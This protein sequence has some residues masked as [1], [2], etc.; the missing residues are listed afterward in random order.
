MENNKTP[1]DKPQNTM[2]EF[3][4]SKSFK[5]VFLGLAGF[6]AIL[7]IFKIGMIA[8]Y[9]KADF[10]RHWIENYHMN[11]GGPRGGF[12]RDFDDRDF[13]G[14]HG[15]AGQVIKIQ[16]SDIVIKGRDN[17]ERIVKVS[18]NTIISRF[19]DSIKIADIKVDEFIVV[20]GEP[21]KDGQIEAKFIRVM[22]AP[23]TGMM[24]DKKFP[25]MRRY[26]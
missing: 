3:F 14:A 24:F 18:D 19:R 5:I 26:Y 23:P 22:P 8:G 13:M 25:P 9:K 2:A 21:N 1:Q 10:S 15:T 11:F 12:F 20:I 7:L 4:Q 6:I 16:D 17:V